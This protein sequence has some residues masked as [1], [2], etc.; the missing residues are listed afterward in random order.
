MKYRAIITIVDDKNNV[1]TTIVK[2][3][4]RQYEMPKNNMI[5]HD[6]HIGFLSIP[7]G[8]ELNY[9]IEEEGNR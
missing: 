9:W 1:I 4:E 8:R 2:D 3:E 6:F 5:I 7:E